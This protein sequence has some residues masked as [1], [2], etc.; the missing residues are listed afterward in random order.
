MRALDARRHRTRAAEP[1]A[2]RRPSCSRASRRWPTRTPRPTRSGRL[3]RARVTL[4]RRRR[5]RARRFGGRPRRRS[6]RSRTTPT[7]EEIVAA[8][9][10]AARAPRFAA[11]RRPASTRCTPRSRCRDGPVAFVRVALPLTAVDE[12]VGAVR[13][14]ALV[15]LGAGLGV[16]ALLTWVA[17]FVLNRRIRAV[18]DTARAL[19][20]GRL[21]PARR[22]ITARDEIGIV[23]N[24]LDDTAR[25]LGAAARGHGA[26]ARAH[27][28][29]S[30]RHGRR[31]RARQRSTAG[32]C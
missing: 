2:A 3:I 11:A 13:R 18:A 5:P 8:R 22:A 14:L 20:R 12:R 19:P 32:S 9:R 10:A 6:R 28:R 4:R 27:G 15:G 29:D 21:Q 23:A 31:R 26:R 17:S 25:Q 24:V 1:G 7:R 16:A 30:H